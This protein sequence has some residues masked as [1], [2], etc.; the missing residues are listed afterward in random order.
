MRLVCRSE[1]LLLMAQ[2]LTDDKNLY[3]KRHLRKRF[4]SAK[5]LLARNRNPL[6]Q[7]TF[8]FCRFR[9]S[10]LPYGLA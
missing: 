4:P 1:P 2:E 8:V 9:S 6:R 3:K 5:A 10:C 7:K